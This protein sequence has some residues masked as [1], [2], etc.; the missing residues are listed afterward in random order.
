[1]AVSR[2][3]KERGESLRKII[4]K[5]NHLYYVLDKPEIEDS[6]Y[7]SLLEE[8]RRLEEEY[9]ALRTKDSPTEKVGGKPVEQF[10]K[11]VHKV[12]QWSFHK[13]FFFKKILYTV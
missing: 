12:S 10:K 13:A 11:I 2:E 6:A 7:D 5:H 1:M 3:I 9:P 4:E 8:L